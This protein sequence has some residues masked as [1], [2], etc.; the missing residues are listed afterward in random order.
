MLG[1]N[2]QSEEMKINGSTPKRTNQNLKSAS[3][4]LQSKVVSKC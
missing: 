3:Q 4:W 2:S 1:W